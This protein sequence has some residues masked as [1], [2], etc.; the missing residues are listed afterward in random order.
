[1]F[2]YYLAV[3]AVAALPFVELAA[4]NPGEPVD[5]ARLLLL[6]TAAVLVAAGVLRVAV[7]AGAN[8][9][10][11]ALL[12]IVGLWLFTHTPT[13]ASWTRFAGFRTWDPIAWGV[14]APIVMVP[15]VPLSRRRWLQRW[16][17]VAAPL[18]LLV[19]ASVAASHAV[20]AGDPVPLDVEPIH[21]E[22]D[23]RPNVYFIVA[24]AYARADVVKATTGLV[25]D[26]FLDDLRGRGFVISERATASYPFTAHSVA[27]TLS[28]QYVGDATIDALFHAIRG[29]YLVRD[30]FEG[31]GY[32]Y[33]HA[34]SGIFE[35]ALCPRDADVCI[36]GTSYKTGTDWGLL[37]KT[38]LGDLMFR[39]IDIPTLA[40]NTDP[41]H[42]VTQLQAAR[43]P[44]T[45]TFTFV[46]LFSPHPP[47]ARRADCTVRDRLGW[48]ISSW[49]RPEAYAEAI[50]CLNQQLLTGLDAILDEDPD[51]VII[52]QGDH[53]SSFE[54]TPTERLPMLSA[55]RLPD[56]CRSLVPDD[57][58][59]VNTFRIVL[60]CLGPPQLPM[61]PARY[62]WG[63][64][65]RPGMA[66]ITDEV[67]G[68]ADPVDE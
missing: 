14:V 33:A 46:H 53:G 23:Q 29:N 1:M 20:T 27:S 67:S 57:L 28:M 52:L 56:E 64:Y 49:P 17:A 6:G 22:F 60:N 24:D 63:H 45:P 13:V 9:G 41:S 38:P 66:E 51:A 42:I 39:A 3:C 61:L 32:S 54:W 35:G 16:V 48:D 15:F 25:I 7:R 47:F 40:T 50:T 12:L 19:P 2:P 55:I 31:A 34:Q 62:F 4:A 37:R 10:R 8:V 30:V 11:A 59:A 18:A 68:L 65:G 43:Q 26:D 58:L 44:P 21:A 36:G 5:G